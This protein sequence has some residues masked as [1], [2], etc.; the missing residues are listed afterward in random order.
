M[1]YIVFGLRVYFSPD[2]N[3]STMVSGVAHNTELGT[4]GPRRVIFDI[5]G[6]FGR[7][8]GHIVE[9]AAGER[10]FDT[11]R[12]QHMASVFLV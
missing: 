2:T 1:N 7:F 11:R 8:L 10:L 4:R 6:I 3:N 9:L 12:V 5:W